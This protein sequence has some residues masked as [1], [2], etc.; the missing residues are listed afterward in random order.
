MDDENT[1]AIVDPEEGGGD[2]E[3]LLAS[4]VVEEDGIEEQEHQA[5]LHSLLSA[6]SPR[7]GAIAYP[8]DRAVREASLAPGTSW[9]EQEQGLMSFRAS[10]ALQVV[11]GTIDRPQ[12]VASARQQIMKL[13]E[14]TVLTARLLLGLWHVRRHQGLVAKNGSVPILISEVLR[15]RGIEKRSRAPFHGASA[16]Y[17]DGYRTEH[18]RGVLEE[19]ALLA[20]FHV[21]GTFTLTH[22][23]ATETFEVRGP[24]LRYSIV[25]RKGR[26]AGFL[27]SPGD[28]INT[29]ELTEVPSLVSVD[30][31]ILRLNPQNQQHALRIALYL[32][33]RW[34]DQ[35][36]QGK[37]EQLVAWLESRGG[38]LLWGDGPGPATGTS[39]IITA[40]QR[41]VGEG[42][43]KAR[44]LLRDLSLPMSELLAASMIEIDSKHLRE[45]FA[46]RIER[47]IAFL[48][49]GGEVQA[50]GGEDKDKGKQHIVG[51]ASRLI[52]I[53]EDLPPR[54]WASTWLGARWVL[55]PPGE[56]MQ[57]YRAAFRPQAARLPEAGAAGARKKRGG[58]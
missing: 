55:L 52:E 40:L 3:Q 6:L 58:E 28:W 17:S 23:G 22:Q 41:A 14:G 43:P 26:I 35:A 45:R 51:E 49:T 7:V 47:A 36:R 25:A 8:P 53:P 21:Q 15:L 13:G 34:L 33:E 2:T 44:T 24:Y 42:E 20:N 50:E 27:V 10:N 56:L 39:G 4:M 5:L 12:D 32:V 16:M 57:A 46:P 37:F 19:V 54:E 18:K 11:L 9:R 1:L 48:T 31:Q 30:E 29:Y 38:S